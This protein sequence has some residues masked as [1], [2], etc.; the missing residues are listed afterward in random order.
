MSPH[1]TN[2][3]TAV[4]V[5]FAFRGAGHAACSKIVSV[6][7]ELPNRGVIGV[8]TKT[9]HIRSQHALSDGANGWNL[10]AVDR[11]LQSL[12]PPN[13]EALCEAGQEELGLMPEVHVLLSP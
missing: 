4:V 12:E 2:G 5:Y 7:T 6:T 10:V 9:R 11:F 3:E 8:R 13:L 1:W